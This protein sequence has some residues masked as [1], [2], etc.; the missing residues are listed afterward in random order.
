MDMEKLSFE[1]VDIEKINRQLELENR[2]NWKSKEK[3]NQTT[4]T[5]FV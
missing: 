3:E 2:F 4:L 5:D 1:N